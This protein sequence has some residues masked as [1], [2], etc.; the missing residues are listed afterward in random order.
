[1]TTG[2]DSTTGATG[3][4]IGGVF[5]MMSFFLTATGLLSFLLHGYSPL[6]TEVTGRDSTDPDFPLT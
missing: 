6:F 5:L 3:V 1:M 4:S 2:L